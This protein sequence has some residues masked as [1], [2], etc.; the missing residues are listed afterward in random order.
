M[1]W[2]AVLIAGFVAGAAAILLADPGTT[3]PP[4]T[5]ASAAVQV[6]TGLPGQ[7]V[8]NADEVVESQ[9]DQPLDAATR[10]QLAA[11]LTEARAVALRYPTEQ[12]A[13][14]AGY[15]LA[16]GFAPGTGAHLVSYSG[17]S[18]P[19]PV[20]VNRPEAY[21][22]DGTSP[23]SRVV[24]LMYY[25]MTKTQPEGFAGSNDLWHRHQGVCVQYSANG[26]NVPLPADSDVTAAQCQAVRGSYLSV[27]GWM[28][29]T[30]VVPGWESPQGVFSHANPNLRCADGTY[31]TDKA[32]FCPGT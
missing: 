28:V 18:G 25:A 10:A 24:G 23:T 15:R 2:L 20:D 4:A 7:H 3:T 31:N 19:G 11:Q 16:G 5:A 17:L 8:H 12:D 30:W 14:Q 22:Y 26:I 1:R 6:N 32:G 9:P 29:H 13:L 21:I 27:T